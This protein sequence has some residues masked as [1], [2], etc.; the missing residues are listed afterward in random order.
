[1]FIMYRRHWEIL[2]WGNKV[3]IEDRVKIR[4]KRQLRLQSCVNNCGLYP[5]NEVF[6][7]KRVVEQFRKKN[8][9]FRGV[10]NIH[11]IFRVQ[12]N[13]IWSRRSWKIQILYK[14][15]FLEPFL[16]IIWPQLSFSK[17]G[18]SEK[19]L[20]WQRMLEGLQWV[21]AKK[22]RMSP[23]G[24]GTSLRVWKTHIQPHL[25]PFPCCLS[26][27]QTSQ[28]HALSGHLMLCKGK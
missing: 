23:I 13:K 16:C 6:K 1:M 25:H 8:D 2:L 12:Q 22:A 9:H 19:R 11:K 18:E 14:H 3:L 4:V 17:G 27:G 5:T 24:L 28:V 10:Y 26:L 7:A 15:I 20:K 21:Y